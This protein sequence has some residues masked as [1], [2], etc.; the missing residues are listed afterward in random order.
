MG[1][2][3]NKGKIVTRVQMAPDMKMTVHEKTSPELLS[4]LADAAQR[5]HEERKEQETRLGGTCQR[6]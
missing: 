2:R 6:K 5:F 3:F 4:M 1:R